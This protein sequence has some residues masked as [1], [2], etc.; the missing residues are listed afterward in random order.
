MYIAIILDF[1][2]GVALLATNWTEIHTR[3]SFPQ[4]YIIS[5]DAMHETIRICACMPQLPD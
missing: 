1:K 4:T 2:V 3:T 5:K